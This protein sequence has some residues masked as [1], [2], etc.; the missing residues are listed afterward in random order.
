M[1]INKSK[2]SLVG[3]TLD[4]GLLIELAGAWPMTYLG[5]PLGGKPRAI[6]FWD[7]ILEKVEKRLHKWKRACLSK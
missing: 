2:C 1:K 6:K 3:I 4:D 7:P 5:L